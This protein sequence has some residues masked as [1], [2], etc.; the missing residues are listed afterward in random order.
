MSIIPGKEWTG[1]VTCAGTNYVFTEAN[2]APPYCTQLRYRNCD[3]RY[4]VF[5]SSQDFASHVAA[6]GPA[7][8]AG[9]LWVLWPELDNGSFTY[10]QG[11]QDDRKAARVVLP[12]YAKRMGQAPEGGQ[13]LRASDINGYGM[14]LR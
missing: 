14:G 10:I 2:R 9:T 1:T 5:V 7:G 11:G 12:G 3:S 4:A 8:L 13:R 6:A